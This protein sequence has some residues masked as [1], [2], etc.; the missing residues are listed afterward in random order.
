MTTQTPFPYP[1][2]NCKNAFPYPDSNCKNPVPYPDSNS[3]PKFDVNAR[4][5]SNTIWA[6]NMA[7]EKTLA[8]NDR[9]VE[10]T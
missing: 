9:K 10:V 4:G 3:D 5:K 2:S 1:D 7:K 6:H 8:I